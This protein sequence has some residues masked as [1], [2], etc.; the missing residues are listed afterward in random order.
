MQ[1]T[2]GEHRRFRRADAEAR[3]IAPDRSQS[4]GIQLGCKTGWAAPVWSY[5]EGAL[6]DESWYQRLDASLGQI[7]QKIMTITND[8]LRATIAAHKEHQNER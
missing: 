3:A 1:C 6:N 5:T 4:S 7:Y 2:P 8:V